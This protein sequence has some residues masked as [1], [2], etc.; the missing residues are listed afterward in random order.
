MTTHAACMGGWCTKREHCPHYHAEYRHQP[1][2]RLCVPG[3]DGFSDV[4]PIR[5]TLPPSAW[6]R[7]ASNAALAPAHPFDVGLHS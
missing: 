3:M 7:A 4:V 6:A 1:A 5:L 2:E